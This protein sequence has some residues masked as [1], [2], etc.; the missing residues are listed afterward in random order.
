M[1]KLK[2]L[3]LICATTLM[4]NTG[5]VAL[6]AGGAAGTG[7]V[8]ANDSRTV[9]TM[10]DDESI[11]LK[12]VNIISN[13]REIYNASKVDAASVNGRVLLTGQCQD[14]NYIHYIITN[15]KQIP[16]VREV[17]NQI[18]QIPPVGM[19]VRTSDS[20]IT[21]KVKTQLLFGKDI[22]SG[23]FKVITENG[24]VYL[25]GLV[26]KDES[27]RAL[28]VA[29]RVDGVKKVVKVFELLPEEAKVSEIFKKEETQV[30]SVKPVTNTNTVEVTTAGDTS[31]IENA[32]IY[33][34]E[35]NA[36]ENPISGTTTTT[37]ANTSNT[38]I[39]TTTQEP[40]QNTTTVAPAG[41]SNGSTQEEFFII[42]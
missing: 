4:F 3:G 35:Q 12:S 41:S 5:C 17:I 29:R 10:I 32:P 25:L 23:R 20:W 38:I 8:V 27:N 39:E 26:T 36:V 6:L 18:D 30:E 31:S 28:N 1:L 9:G 33:F 11:E 37:P 2:A 40:I 19:G 14:S 22:N 21:T 16:Q 7:L 34:E 42:D 24:V 13:N 15:I